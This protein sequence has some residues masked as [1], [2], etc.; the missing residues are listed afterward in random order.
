MGHGAPI[1]VGADCF[2]LVP[3]RPG[4]EPG[5]FGGTRAPHRQCWLSAVDR[6]PA[7]LIADEAHTATIAPCLSL[8]ETVSRSSRCAPGAQASSSAEPSSWATLLW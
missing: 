3:R 5:L 1:S 8:A 7:L 6:V 4:S 2:R